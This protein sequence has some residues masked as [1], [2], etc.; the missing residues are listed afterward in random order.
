MFCRYTLNECH[1]IPGIVQGTRDMTM[2]AKDTVADF[3]E[4]AVY[5]R[6]MGGKTDDHTIRNHD[7]SFEGTFLGAGEYPF[8]NTFGIFVKYDYD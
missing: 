2:S 6:G 3:V 8:L 1:C 5:A 4:T 7:T